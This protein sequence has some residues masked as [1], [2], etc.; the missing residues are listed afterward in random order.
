MRTK[1]RINLLWAE[2]NELKQIV[3]KQTASQNLVKRAKI[4]L[5]FN[6]D[7]L[8]N[9]SVAKSLK[10]YPCEVTL[11][12]KRWI[13]CSLEPVKQRLSDIPRPGAPSQITAE[14]WCQ[15][16]ALACEPP[17]NYDY[18]ITHWSTSELRTEILK[19][20]IVEH[21]STS[22]LNNFLKKQSCNPTVVATGSILNQTNAMKNALSIYA[23][24]IKTR[25]KTRMKS[26]SV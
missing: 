3:R 2:L 25:C 10:I 18:P 13:E 20:G 7:G 22:H 24:A 26:H 23:N 21:I 15:I 19:Q 12:T 9:R 14:Q 17:V 16:I 1:Y 5:L 11:W 8:S 4:I 6:E